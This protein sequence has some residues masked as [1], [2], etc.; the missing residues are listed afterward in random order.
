MCLCVGAEGLG[1][2]RVSSRS[3]HDNNVTIFTLLLYSE[4]QARPK[5]NKTLLSNPCDLT[6]DSKTK[7]TKHQALGPCPVFAWDVSLFGP[8]VRH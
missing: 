6:H 3:E 7:K 8:A 1:G 2:G 4:N 5:T